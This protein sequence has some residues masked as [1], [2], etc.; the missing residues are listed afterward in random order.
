MGSEED[1]RPGVKRRSVPGLRT[2]GGVLTFASCLPMLSALPAAVATVLSTVGVRTTSGPFA[3]VA[4]ALAPV[5]SPLLVLATLVLV[6]GM[7]RRCGIQPAVLVWTAGALLYM[8]MYV[9]P[10][11]AVAR[12]RGLPAEHSPTAEMGEMGG[13]PSSGSSRTPAPANAPVFYSGLALFAGSF[14]WSGLRRRRGA[15]RPMPFRT[16]AARG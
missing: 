6:V 11:S 10:A 13:E 5:A 1:L 2:L 12:M 14:V 9:L 8:S 16:S 15:C 7:L 3:P 4:R